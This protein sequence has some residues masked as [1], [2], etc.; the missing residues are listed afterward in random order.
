[1]VNYM[2]KTFSFKQVAKIKVCNQ[3][4]PDAYFA[5]LVEGKLLPLNNDK[6]TRDFID[7]NIRNQCTTKNK[8]KLNNVIAIILESPHIYEFENN[9]TPKGP[10]CGTTGRLFFDKFLNLLDASN[11]REF[12]SGEYNLVFVNS[13]QYQTSCGLKLSDNK[14]KIKRD[15]N[16]EKV[17]IDNGGEAD[18]KN[19]LD[20]LKPVCIMNLCT[21]GLKNLQL[22]VDR[23]ILRYYHDGIYTYGSHPSTWNFSYAYIK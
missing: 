16:W 19:R 6:K 2:P 4:C 17:F 9:T 22:E 13:V 7:Y 14:N 18:L 11:L 10:A 20:A 15:E 3:P 8:V 12:L 21:K 1:M 23:S 5:N